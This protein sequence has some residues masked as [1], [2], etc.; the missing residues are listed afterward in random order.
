[1]AAQY[2]RAVITAART[3]NRVVGLVYISAVADHAGETVRSQLDK[4]ATTILGHIKVAVGRVWM[5]PEGIKHFAGN[6]PDQQQKVVWAT[7]FAP[8]ADLSP[9]D[10]AIDPLFPPY[11]EDKLQALNQW[12]DY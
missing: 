9:P 8:D 5:L 3:D 6:L 7:H 1:M 2:G 11:T 4:Y 10:V 12:F